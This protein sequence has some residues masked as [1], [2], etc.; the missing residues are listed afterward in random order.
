[1][2]TYCLLPLWPSFRS[3][4]SH[5]FDDQGRL[6]DGTG[7]LINWWQPATSQQF[8]TR[9]TCLVN[10]YSSYQV[11]PG[12]YVNGNLTLGE[13]IADNGGVK[14]AF[15][16]F[17]NHLHPG[18]LLAAEE[19]R[20]V[21]AAPSKMMPELSNEQLFFLSYGQVWC[22]KAT[23]DFLRLRVKTDVHSPAPFRV[24][25]PLQNSDE[26]AAAF[27]CPVGSPMNPTNKCQLW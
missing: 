17:E 5:G 10:Q 23:D 7:K 14:T 3:E 12:V 24:L 6:Y 15:R 4:L 19:R 22:T 1:L 21:L 11:L 18:G 27:Q 16:A 25:G 13:N 8:E 2:E 9:A 26:F 20:Q